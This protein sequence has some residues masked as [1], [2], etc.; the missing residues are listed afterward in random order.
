MLA[1]NTTARIINP[2]H[3]AADYHPATTAAYRLG[4]Y[5]AQ[6]GEECRATKYFVFPQDQRD[7]QRGYASIAKANEVQQ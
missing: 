6:L 4:A 7:Y 2:P 5:A 1:I 3:V